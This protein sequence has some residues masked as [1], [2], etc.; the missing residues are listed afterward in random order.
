MRIIN[1]SSIGTIVLNLVMS[2]PPSYNF[3]GSAEAQ[4]AH[5]APICNAKIRGINAWGYIL[6]PFMKIVEEFMVNH[7]TPNTNLAAFM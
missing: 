7:L 5:I 3:L 4:A 2:M 6:E 1:E